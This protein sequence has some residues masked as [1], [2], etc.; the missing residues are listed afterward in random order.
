MNLME[1]TIFAILVS[2]PQP[3]FQCKMTP[4]EKMAICSNDLTISEGEGG[5][6]TFSNNVTVEKNRKRELVFSNGLSS[7]F[8][9]FGWLR[10]SN[11]YAMRR[12]DGDVFRVSPPDRKSDM[13]CRYTQPKFVV[14]C[15]PV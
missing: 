6:L 14:R 9:S 4:D 15:S 10:F 2:T 8:D 11:D 1:A 5:K 13:H 3:P 12:V 7:R